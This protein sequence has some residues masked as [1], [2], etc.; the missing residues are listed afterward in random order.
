M[1]ESTLTN[2]AWVVS[3]QPVASFSFG[4]NVGDGNTA[5][6]AAPQCSIFQMTAY[7][8]F[9]ASQITGGQSESSESVYVAEVQV[10]T[11]A[12]KI[13]RVNNDAF[14]NGKT[15]LFPSAVTVPSGAV[16]VGWYDG[17]NDPNGV[18]VEYFVAKATDGGATFPTQ[19]AVSDVPFDPCGASSPCFF[20]PSNTQLAAG[21]GGQ[22][23]AAW[24]DFRDG[25][26]LAIW[27]QTITW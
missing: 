7:C 16:Y 1:W 11:G 6:S 5:S 22:V 18:N 26:S 17:R 19:M 27:S 8:A 21:P 10:A 13:V 14:G 12:S 25:V 2:G 24:S 23:H 4:G 15:H 20:A 9:S 3:A